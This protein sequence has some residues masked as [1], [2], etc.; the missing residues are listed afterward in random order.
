MHFHAIC[1]DVL[2][3][4]TAEKLLKLSTLNGTF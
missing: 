1:G 2:E 4:G 3:V